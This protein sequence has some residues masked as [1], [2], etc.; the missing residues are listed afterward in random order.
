MRCPGV[1]DSNEFTLGR[2]QTPAP[3]L[4]CA[5]GSASSVSNTAF[6]ADDAPASAA[7]RAALPLQKTPH[8]QRQHSCQRKQRSYASLDHT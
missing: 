8:S 3:F 7:S 1:T 5:A 2:V 4:P 6:A